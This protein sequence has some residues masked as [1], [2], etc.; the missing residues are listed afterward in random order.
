M[1]STWLP[2]FLPSGHHEVP[3]LAYRLSLPAQGKREGRGEAPSGLILST[4]NTTPY[5]TGT[6]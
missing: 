3:L 2:S 1:G 4:W 6:Q 5:I